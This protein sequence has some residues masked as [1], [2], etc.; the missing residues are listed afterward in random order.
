MYLNTET[1]HTHVYIGK[2]HRR[3]RPGAEPQK[4]A[5]FYTEKGWGSLHIK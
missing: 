2:L 1:T 5:K 4:K 3:G